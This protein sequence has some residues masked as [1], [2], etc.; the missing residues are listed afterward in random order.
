[1]VADP[2]RNLGGARTEIAAVSKALSAQPGWS[3][4]ILQGPQATSPML[5]QALSGAALFHY[6]GH[7]RYGDALGWNSALVLSD[8]TRF[9]VGD[10]LTL[11]DAPQVVVLSGCETATR[12]GI[13]APSMGLANAFIAAGSTAVIA[14]SRSVDDA[15]ARDVTQAFYQ[16][17][18]AGLDIADALRAAQ[19]DV[20]RTTPDRDWSAFRLIEP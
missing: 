4:S 1:M 11:R 14:T 6:A 15:S 5:R 12:P 13:A 7:A 8:D 2:S 10:I 16:H 9:D 20:R 18:L 19:L 3:G 17:W